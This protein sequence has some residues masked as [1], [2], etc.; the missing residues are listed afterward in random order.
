MSWRIHCGILASFLPLHTR[1]A[2]RSQRAACWANGAD[3][4]VSALALSLPGAFN[5]GAGGGNAVL[6][7][8]GERVA[9]PED[10]PQTGNRPARLAED[11][12]SGPSWKS[13]I[14][15]PSWLSHAITAVRQIQQSMSSRLMDTIRSRAWTIHLECCHPGQPGNTPDMV[16]ISGS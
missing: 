10:E 13:G 14:F 12:A 15:V 7:A 11:E 2:I 6:A 16:T 8:A 5:H 3:S 4:R 9:D 1:L